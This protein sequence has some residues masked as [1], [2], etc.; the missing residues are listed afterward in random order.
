LT[1]TYDF[2]Y[3]T[4]RLWLAGYSED[5]VPLSKDDM[6]ED[7]ME[8][9]ANK[10]VTYEPQPHMG[11]NHLSIHPCKHANVMKHLIDVA[12]DNGVKVEVHH[13][14]FIFLKFISS[15]VPTME[16]DFTV[17]IELAAN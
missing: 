17:D 7:I 15:V 4:P 10:T 6:F 5:N 14:M 2:Y 9:Y 11:V 1:I 12:S 8:D 3:L 13:A 16:Y